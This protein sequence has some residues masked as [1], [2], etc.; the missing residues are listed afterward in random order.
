MVYL[1]RRN[2]KARVFTV[3][4]CHAQFFALRFF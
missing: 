1:R 3:A 4:F 2:K